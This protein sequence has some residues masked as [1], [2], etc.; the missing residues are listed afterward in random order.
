MRIGLLGMNSVPQCAQV[1]SSMSAPFP[2]SARPP[3]VAPARGSLLVDPI[4]DLR[5]SKD[6]F[7][8]F[9]GVIRLSVVE[10]GVQLLKG[11]G[12]LAELH[13]QPQPR[14]RRQAEAVLKRA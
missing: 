11:P 13:A 3:A 10:A 14:H 8:S 2:V 6:D 1:R 7:G 5:R 9:H 12:R 4:P